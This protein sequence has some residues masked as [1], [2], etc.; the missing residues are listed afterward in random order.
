MA[1]AKKKAEEE[2]ENNALLEASYRKALKDMEL[3][4]RQVEELQGVNDKLE[5]S[6]RKVQAELEDLTV[7]QEDQRHK[8]LELEKRQRN[9]DKIL[10][11]EKVRSLSNKFA[12]TS[13][14]RSKLHGI[15]LADL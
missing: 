6:K 9:F 13:I 2:N 15:T 1:E 10:A 3:L 12:F 8:F 7:S 14:G 11:E 5:K 4:Q